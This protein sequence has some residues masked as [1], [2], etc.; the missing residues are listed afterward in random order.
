MST[1]QNRHDIAII[2]DRF[3]AELHKF[4]VKVNLTR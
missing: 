2:R 1:D 4:G 3:G